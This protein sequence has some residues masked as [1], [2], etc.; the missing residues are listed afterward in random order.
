[1]EEQPAVMRKSITHSELPMTLPPFIEQFG[2]PEDKALALELLRLTRE[3]RV[4]L[5]QLSLYVAMSR[6]QEFGEACNATDAREGR[7]VILSS[8]LRSM[9]VSIAAVF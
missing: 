4:L 1:M 2:A 3:L 8:L 9:V 7:G 5:S 6:S